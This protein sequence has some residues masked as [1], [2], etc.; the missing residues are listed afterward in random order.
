ME[1]VANIQPLSRKARLDNLRSEIAAVQGQII[2]I[3]NGQGQGSIDIRQLV[4]QESALKQRLY[5]QSYNF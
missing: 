4:T 3:Q 5:E 1:E 2:A